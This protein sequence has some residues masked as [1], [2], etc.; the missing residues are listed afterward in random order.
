MAKNTKKTKLFRVWV[1]YDTGV[2]T[3]VRAKDWLEARRKG[4]EFIRNKMDYQKFENQ[5]FENIQ[6]GETDCKEV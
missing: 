5:I 3:I 4:Q 6:E 1:H 2:D